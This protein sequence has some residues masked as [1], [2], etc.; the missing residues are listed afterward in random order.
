[1]EQTQTCDIC[2]G[3]GFVKTE[4]GAVKL[5][6]CRYNG[7]DINKELNIPKR[8]WKA[9][10]ETFRPDYPSQD[11]AL[12]IAKRFAYSFDPEDGKGITF[13]GTPGVGKTH[14][15][16]ATLK[17]IYEVKKVRGIFF[18]TKDLIYRLRR[19]MEEG[20]D[21]KFLNAILNVPLLVLDD[22][23][24]ER[25]SDW[26]RELISYIITHRYNNLKSTII[27]TNFKLDREESNTK[28]SYDLGT[29]LGE[30]VVSKIYEMN[31]IL[32]IKGEDRRK[33]NRVECQ[34]HFNFSLKTPK[35]DFS[36]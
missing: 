14:L 11:T 36:G 23:G 33:L 21:I 3:T 8:Y 12:M 9:S 31:E 32:I 7:K 6:K 28:I 4:K 10:F 5:C 19:S 1:M 27:T 26:Q 30:N 22:L 18:D 34:P 24:S 2:N 29:R 20:K 16:V 15:A 35:K 13:I 17:A 25:L